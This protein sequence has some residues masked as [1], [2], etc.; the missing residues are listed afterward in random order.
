M[1]LLESQT[2]LFMT[3]VSILPV[4][5]PQYIEDRVIRLRDLQTS[6]EMDLTLPDIELSPD[7]VLLRGRF[8]SKTL[9]DGLSIHCS[10]STEEKAFTSCAHQ[11]AG[12]SCIFFLQGNVDLKVGSKT[13]SFDAHRY[14]K[15][16]AAG[17]IRRGTEPFQRA[18]RQPQAIKHLVV[19][20]SQQW[21]QDSGFEEGFEQELSEQLSHAN[22]ALG[23]WQADKRLTSLVQDVM[24]PN[25]IPPALLNLHLESRSIEIISETLSNLLNEAK[26]SKAQQLSSH[27][28]IRLQRACDF[29][30]DDPSQL[31]SVDGVAKQAG[32]SISG[33]Q[34]LFK[35]VYGCSV[36]DYIRQV[37][38]NKAMSLLKTGEFSVDQV[39]Y[40]VGYNRPANF[41]TAFK[42]HFGVTPSQA[43]GR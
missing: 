5:Q 16:E 28:K 34:R 43:M 37:R 17:L 15:I 41:S 3:K 19:T 2:S 7:D 9:R 21:L 35:R 13:F 14:G 30:L 27:D 18:T 29:I 11:E 24:A 10:D 42:R 40:Y 32:I 25:A 20:A 1:A 26:Q 33:L 22:M 4:C 38:L 8:F 12:L 39:S 31:L 6:K 36:F 23:Q